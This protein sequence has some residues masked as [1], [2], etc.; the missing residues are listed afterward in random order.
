MATRQFALAW[1]KLGAKIGRKVSGMV[2]QAE[3]QHAGASRPA[4]MSEAGEVRSAPR[5]RRKLAGPAGCLP[6]PPGAFLFPVCVVGLVAPMVGIRSWWFFASL[7]VTVIAA[8]AFVHVIFPSTRFFA[9]AFAN[10]LAAYECVFN[11][12]VEANFG[13]VATLVLVTGFALSIIVFCIPAGRRRPRRPSGAW[14]RWPAA[15]RP[16]RRPTGPAG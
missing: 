12:F 1:R 4:T 6:Q 13:G 15:S 9:V 16:A 10:A 11:V 2:A 3:R 7:L 5:A 14:W 8:T